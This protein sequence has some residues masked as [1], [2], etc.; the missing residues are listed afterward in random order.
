LAR[1]AGQIAIGTLLRR[2]GH[3][4]LA[5]RPEHFRWRPTP[6]FRGLVHLPVTTGREAT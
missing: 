5:C 4:A 1:S 2:F 3:L 6:V